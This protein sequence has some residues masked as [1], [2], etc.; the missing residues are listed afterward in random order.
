[1]NWGIR[2]LLTGDFLGLPMNLSQYF[3]YFLFAPFLPYF[4]TDPWSTFQVCPQGSV[5]K[6][7]KKNIKNQTLKILG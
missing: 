7:D 4:E 2:G 5:S 1:M 3:Q 6:S